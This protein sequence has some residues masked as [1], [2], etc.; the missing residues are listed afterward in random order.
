MEKEEWVNAC[1]C[2]FCRG[3]RLHTCTG[4]DCRTAAGRAEE[5]YNQRRKE[6]MKNK[7]VYIS[8]PITGTEDYMQR[9]AEAE[10]ELEEQGCTYIVNPAKVNGML[11]PGTSYGQYMAMSFTMMEPCDTV[12]LLR[13]WEGSCGA[14]REYARAME[15]G[16]EAIQ[17][18]GGAAGCF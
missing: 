3:S 10:K 2:S 14:L 5:Y 11:P 12:Y 8:G 16:M 18:E 4:Y 7:K 13:G 15:K 9:F 6:G 1:A 17:Q